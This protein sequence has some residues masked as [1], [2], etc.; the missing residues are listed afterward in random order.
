MSRNTKSVSALTLLTAIT[1][2]ISCSQ[3]P[4][5]CGDGQKLD[6]RTQF[7]K[8]SKTWDKCGGSEYDPYGQFC[9][10][11][12]L[13]DKCNG[14]NFDP[15]THF[16][17]LGKVLPKCSGETYDPAT[18]TCFFGSVISSGKCGVNLYDPDNQVC[19]NSKIYDKPYAPETSKQMCGTETIANDAAQFCYN[20][21]VYAKRDG[22]E[23]VPDNNAQAVCGTKNYDGS[24]SFC[25]AGDVFPLCG[26]NTYN[27]TAYTC[28]NGKITDGSGGNPAVPGAGKYKVTVTSAGTG[29]T[30]AGN[31][32]E[33]DLVQIKAGTAPSG[34][35]FV[36][37]TT[38]SA[39]VAFNSETSP[40]TTFKM[41][42]HAV[43]VTAVFES[44]NYVDVRDG[45]KYRMVQIGGQVWMG[46]NLNYEIGNGTKSWC[47]DNKPENC[48]KYGR[49][50]NWSTA[51]NNAPSSELSPSGVQGVCPSGWHLP[52]RAEWTE[53]I[54]ITGPAGRTLQSTQANG[55][56][57]YNFSALFSGM[58]SGYDNNPFLYV[59]EDAIWWTATEKDNDLAYT[60]SINF[61]G[62]G[63]VY[64]RDNIKRA[65][66]SVRCVMDNGGVNP[67]VPGATK[68]AVTVTGGTG[69]TGEG[70]YTAGDLVTIAAGTPPAGGTFSEWTTASAGVTFTNAKSARTTFT[71][72]ANAVI[73]TAVFTSTMLTD[74]RDGKKYKITKI[75]GQTWMAENLNYD[76]AEAS[77]TTP[78][79]A[80]AWCYENADSNCVKYGRL[81]SWKTAM[82]GEPSSDKNPS[83]VQGICPAGWH[84]P[85]RPEWFDLHTAVNQS[86]KTLIPT[87]LNGTDDYGFSALPGGYRNSDGSFNDVGSRS[88]WWTTTEIGSYGARLWYMKFNDDYGMGESN[89]GYKRSGLSV[90]CIQDK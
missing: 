50:Y 65:G 10:A 85:S 84:L 66:Y 11:G 54:N 46:E 89:D 57:D 33:G 15:V 36:K 19:V 53:L 47:Y 75:G 3:A 79:A 16:C 21:K 64:D 1:L 48:E 9:N 86:A 30:G 60:R 51:M 72:P 74:I 56:D 71:M 31:Y 25:Y 6:S 13:Y 70:N 24:K 40:T 59:G 44:T 18:Q 4:E 28:E 73:V 29:A 8:D 43:T 37:W 90:R 45:N 23:Y 2:F 5:N 26:G 49:L 68:Y 38:E 35:R 67:V 20:D 76:T 52:S 88:N 77:G 83:E 62:A 17:N 81:Y 14:D 42:N 63:G 80:G 7:C 58:K 39:G 69:A 34:Y 41:P 87:N 61:A 82:V 78:T 32:N 27:P 55:T 22:Q 12:K